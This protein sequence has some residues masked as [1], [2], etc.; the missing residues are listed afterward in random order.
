VAGHRLNAINLLTGRPHLAHVAL[1]LIDSKAH[2]FPLHC[3]AGQVAD[4]D[5]DRIG[6]GS[7]GAVDSLGN[8]AFCA[9]GAHTASSSS[10]NDAAKGGRRV[11]Q[12][13]MQDHVGR[14]VRRLPRPICGALLP[15]REPVALTKLCRGQ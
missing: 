12:G 7:I 1:G 3:E 6:T 4:L 14:E 5:P 11:V 13:R 8:D 10:K 9:K 2:S 15:A